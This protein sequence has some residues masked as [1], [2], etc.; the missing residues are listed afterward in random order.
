MKKELKQA[1]INYIFENY[2]VFNLP[3]V[4]IDKFRNYIYDDK[5]EYLIGGK[6]N[7]DFIS[8][9]IKLIQTA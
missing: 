3:N 1:I 6:E 9:A 8:Q 4:T 7:S 2:N 5:G